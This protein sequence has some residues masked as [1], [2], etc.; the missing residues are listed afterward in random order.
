MIWW[1]VVLGFSCFCCKFSSAENR[2]RS[3]GKLRVSLNSMIPGTILT[4]TFSAYRPVIAYKMQR[5]VYSI[6][7]GKCLFS[8]EIEST[9][10]FQ[11]AE[12]ILGWGFLFPLL[13]IFSLL[14]C[15][16]FVYCLIMLIKNIEWNVI[17]TL[18]FKLFFK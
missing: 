11:I 5:E 14:E 17:F 8:L 10:M 9:L 4:W 2:T 7:L 6:I 18:F 13:E 16:S 12:W 3:G 1:N 15:S